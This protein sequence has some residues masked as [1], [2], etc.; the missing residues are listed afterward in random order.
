MDVGIWLNDLQWLYNNLNNMD[1]TAISDRVFALIAIGNLPLRDPDWRSFAVRLR[2]R[3]NQYDAV[4]PRPTPIHSKKFTSA[5]RQEYV[6]RN[7]DNPDVQ[8]HIFTARTNDNLKHNQSND[9]TSSPPSKRARQND[10]VTLCTAEVMLEGTLRNGV[11]LGIFIFLFP[12]GLSPITFA[13]PLP[14]FLKAVNC[15]C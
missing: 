11:G 8:A 7:R 13:P 3:I 5:I 14:H 4:R 12:S 2:Q 15:T 1:P 9:Q 10:Q 6:F